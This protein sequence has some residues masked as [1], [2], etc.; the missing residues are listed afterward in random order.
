M[1]G[2]NVR[3]VGARNKSRRMPSKSQQNQADI[4]DLLTMYPDAR[5]R[6]VRLL[7]EVDTRR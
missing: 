1:Y 3:D 2:V 6:V 4:I 5:R 7:A